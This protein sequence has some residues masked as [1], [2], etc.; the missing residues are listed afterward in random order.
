[1]RS[2][3]ASSTSGS[4][5]FASCTFAA[6]SCN[7]QRRALAIDQDVVRAAGFAAVGGFGPVRSPPRFARTLT[8]S[9]LARLQA[10]LPD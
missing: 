9:R 2:R 8:P 1:M 7:R 4:S 6:V 5:R 10:D 3:S